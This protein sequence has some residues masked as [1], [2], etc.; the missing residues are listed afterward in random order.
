MTAY[1]FSSLCVSPAD[2][3][4]RAFDL[5]YRV[6]RHFLDQAIQSSQ[7][8]LLDASGD[9][10]RLIDLVAESLGTSQDAVPVRICIPLLGSPGWG[11]PH[12]KVRVSFRGALLS[13]N[14][15]PS[16]DV[17]QF[18]YS[19]RTLLRR[20]P[21][22]CASVGLPPYMSADRWGGPGWLN[23]LSWLFDASVTIAGFSGEGKL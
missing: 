22:A 9:W 13:Y 3:F 11:D 10:T 19:L 1:D 8:V 14:V 5:T 17:L 20:C 2:D 4:C 7:L 18:V 16:Q 23:K 15:I 12:P 21:H 6:P